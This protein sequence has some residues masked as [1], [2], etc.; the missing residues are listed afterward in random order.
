MRWLSWLRYCTT[1]RKVAVV[2]G[3]FHGHNPSGCT[4]A[5]GSAPNS[6][7]H[8]GEDHNS[9]TQQYFIKFLKCINSNMGYMFRLTSSHLQALKM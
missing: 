7:Y 2:I 4:T 8:E 9:Q 1:S 6:E 5:L 3:I